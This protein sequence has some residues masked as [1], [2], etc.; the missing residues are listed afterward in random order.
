MKDSQIADN[1][2]YG[3]RQNTAVNTMKIIP[4]FIDT[5]CMLMTTGG[6]GMGGFCPFCSPFPYQSIRSN[7]FS[8]LPVGGV[9]VTLKFSKFFF[10]SSFFPQKEVLFLNRSRKG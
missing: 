1:P 9:V 4:I 3:E 6:V 5:Y 2:D 7:I 8:L 10:P